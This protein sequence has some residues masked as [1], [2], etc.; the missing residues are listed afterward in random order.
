MVIAE[1]TGDK[2]RLYL[3][4]FS[5]GKSSPR[6]QQVRLHYQK[7]KVLHAV[8]AVN[9]SLSKT[10][11]KGSIM[12]PEN[13]ISPKERVEDACCSPAVCLHSPRGPVKH[14]EVPVY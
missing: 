6:A 4:V 9:P 8:A 11:F 3:I 5:H 14:R 12:T 2:T 7:P 10:N 13:I 1:C